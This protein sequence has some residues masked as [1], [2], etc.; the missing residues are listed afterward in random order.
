[1]Q[2][3][4]IKPEPLQPLPTKSDRYVPAL[5]TKVG[6][7]TALREASANTWSRTTPLIQVLGPKTLEEPLRAA[8]ITGWMKRIHEAVGDHPC[9]L[10]VIRL[11]PTLRVSTG[12]GEVPVLRQLYVQARKRGL[13]FMPV[14]WVGRSTKTHVGLAA[15]AALEDGHGL[16]LRYRFRTDMPPPEMTPAD[17]VR[18]QLSEAGTELEE[19]DLILDCEY[20]DP[21]DELDPLGVAELLSELE[22]VG[23]WRSLVLL[24]T[25]IPKQMSSVAEGTVGSVARTERDLWSKVRKSVWRIPAF[26][27]Y[28]VQHPRPPQDG[29]PGMRAN[30]RYTIGQETLVARGMG[31]ITQEGNTQYRGLCQQLVHRSEFSGAAYS[32]GD[33]VIEGCA[34]GRVPPRGQDLWRGAGTSHHLALV[35]EELQEGP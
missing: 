13:R 2:T 3:S 25:S 26:G 34:A 35:T 16:A 24:G 19:T 10:D 7:L 31:P 29:G 17:H 21:D 15:D 1:M 33:G 12:K 4:L 23:S 8:R 5:Q 20:I 30:I 9:Y 11:R 14:I 6:E 32:W 22:D 18:S 27:D 28:A